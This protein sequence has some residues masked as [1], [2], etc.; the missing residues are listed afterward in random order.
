MFTPYK[1]FFWETYK[2]RSSF[3]FPVVADLE[4]LTFGIVQKSPRDAFKFLLEGERL[5]CFSLNF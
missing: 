3:S 1:A 5:N 4:K 2:F